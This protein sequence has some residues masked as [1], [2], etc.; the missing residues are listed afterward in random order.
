[1]SAGG[2]TEASGSRPTWATA[3]SKDQAGS[4]WWIHQR[5][6]SPV[7]CPSDATGNRTAEPARLY[8]KGRFLSK[9]N[10]AYFKPPSLELV[11]NTDRKR[12]H[13]ILLHSFQSVFF[14]TT[15][16]SEMNSSARE[17]D[18]PTGWH[19]FDMVWAQLIFFLSIPMFFTWACIW[20]WSAM[21]SYKSHTAR[22]EREFSTS[23]S[24]NKT[25]KFPQWGFKWSQ[26]EVKRQLDES[27][28]ELLYSSARLNT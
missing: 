12:I 27:I 4:L 23:H 22:Y 17:G 26:A 10:E 21:Q 24:Y 13:L 6:L 16:F 2:G 5:M 20:K 19:L 7:K 25:W 1:M 8:P 14:L 11:W 9:T 28:L 15:L 18:F 3:D